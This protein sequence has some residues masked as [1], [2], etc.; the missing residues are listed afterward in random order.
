MRTLKV[1]L[2]FPILVVDDDDGLAGRDVGDRAARTQSNLVIAA[3]S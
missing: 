1:S 2:V 3:T